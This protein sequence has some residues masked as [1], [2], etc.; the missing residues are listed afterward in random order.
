MCDSTQCKKHH[1]RNDNYMSKIVQ[2]VPKVKNMYLVERVKD[3]KN[4]NSMPVW[5]ARVVDYLTLDDDGNIGVLVDDEVVY[6][7]RT[8]D[9]DSLLMNE[10]RYI[11]CKRDFEHNGH[12]VIEKF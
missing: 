2:I 11:A 12:T 7:V 10:P 4:E 3:G 8:K 9:K 5:C 1:E 6:S